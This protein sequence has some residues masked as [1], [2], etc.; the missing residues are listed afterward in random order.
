MSS[1][2]SGP[3]SSLEGTS[4]SSCCFKREWDDAPSDIETETSITV[5]F[6]MDPAR[7]LT[8]KGPVNYLLETA[9]NG[10]SGDEPDVSKDW[11]NFGVIP[12][13]MSKEERKQLL[14]DILGRLKEDVRDEIRNRLLAALDRAWELMMLTP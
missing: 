4:L 8:I 12:L 9:K 10:P 2:A 1:S 3:K 14:D 5:D 7:T 13:N 6:T 11:T